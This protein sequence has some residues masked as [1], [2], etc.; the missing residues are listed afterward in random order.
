MNIALF[1]RNIN[2]GEENPILSFVNECT[3]DG[4][5]VYISHGLFDRIRHKE[6]LPFDQVVPFEGKLPSVD[7]QLLISVGGD[8]TFLRAARLAGADEI[9]IAGINTGRLGFMA[10]TSISEMIDLY[11]EFIRGE[12]N[13]ERRTQLSLQTSDNLHLECCL[14]LNEIAI[15]RKDTSSLIV[16]HVYVN[17][18]LLNSYWADGLIISTPTGSTAYSLSAGGPIMVPDS[19]SLVLTPIAPHSLTTRPIVLPLDVE[20]KLRVESRSRQYM[21]SIDS[22]SETFSTST[23]L[24]VKKANHSVMVVQRKNYDFFSTLRKKL[25]WGQDIRTN[26]H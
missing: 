2:N 3:K 9:P 14:A 6:A 21:V 13:I 26:N 12:C 15:L 19:N 22:N 1:G 7:I 10:E 23:E 8:G 16:T 5:V 17:G 11:R 20:I 25:M 4:N 18:H 24:V